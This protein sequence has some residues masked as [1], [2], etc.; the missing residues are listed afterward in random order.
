M[1]QQRL[2]VVGLL[3]R[4][5]PVLINPRRRGALH[6]RNVG[7]GQ[8]HQKEAFRPCQYEGWRN[9]LARERGGDGVED[10]LRFRAAEGWLLA[11]HRDLPFTRRTPAK[12]ANAKLQVSERVNTHLALRWMVQQPVGEAL[13]AALAFQGELAHA[14]APEIPTHQQQES[15][16]QAQE[17]Q[18][19]HASG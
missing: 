18:G 3:G 5:S 15:G 17:H 11:P 13:D 19:Q 7:I 9:H 8:C 2:V 14:A 6:N 4:V 16:Q 12:A 10:P 1:R